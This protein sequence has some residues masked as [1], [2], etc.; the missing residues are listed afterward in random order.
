VVFLGHP[1]HKFLLV[2]EWFHRHSHNAVC[3]ACVGPLQA[4]QWLYRCT[5]CNYDVHAACV[6]LPQ[7]V[8]HPSHYQ[9]P[10]KLI[11][12]PHAGFTCDLCRG[13][14]RQGLLYECAICDFGVHLVCPASRPSMA[15]QIG[16]SSTHMGHEMENLALNTLNNLASNNSRSNNNLD[17]SNGIASLLFNAIFQN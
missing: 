16:S 17:P 14:S 2:P 10:L 6:Q 9:H 4:T 1:Q 8:Q 7:V 3:D 11:M 13:N 15:T 5:P 12:V